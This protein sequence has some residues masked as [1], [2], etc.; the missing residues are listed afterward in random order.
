VSTPD[1]AATARRDASAELAVERA[2]GVSLRR[3]KGGERTWLVVA[4]AAPGDADA[5]R[6]ATALVCE[7]DGEL[8]AR[9]GDAGD[10]AAS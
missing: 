3:L 5:L 10:E 1:Q 4:K 2:A 6:A 9:Y 7:L 8:E